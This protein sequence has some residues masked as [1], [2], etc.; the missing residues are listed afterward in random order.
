MTTRDTED[1]EA[2]EILE[3]TVLDEFKRPNVDQVYQIEIVRQIIEQA[4][5]SLAVGS[6]VL[7]SLFVF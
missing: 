1:A 7:L 4:A 5:F 3:T 6:S 2:N